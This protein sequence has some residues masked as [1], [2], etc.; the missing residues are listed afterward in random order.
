MRK[1]P[2]FLPWAAAALLAASLASPA[3][4]LNAKAQQLFRQ[5]LDENRAGNYGRALEH[6]FQAHKEDPDVLA[7]DDEGLLSAAADWLGRELD[8]DDT[9]HHAHFQMAELRM[10]EGYPD[11]ALPHY[12]R[13]VDLAPGSGLA[14]LAKP[15]IADIKR[16]MKAQSM[17]FAAQQ[18]AAASGASTASLESEIQTL[19]D[20][21]SNLRR[22]NEELRRDLDRARSQPD[23]SQD[24]ERL[25]KEYDDFKKQAELWRVSHVRFY[26]GGR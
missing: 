15:L 11:E 16:D 25:K 3:A 14:N 9:D 2:R 13:V 23:V 5:A 24:Y 21:V 19:K 22:E 17:A 10:L 18:K 26:S 12:Q 1:R 7:M 20:E 8:A 4:A 6:Y